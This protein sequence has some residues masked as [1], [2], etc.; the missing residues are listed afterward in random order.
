M[1]I[2]NALLKLASGEWPR[3][4]TKRLAGI[5]DD[6]GA[7]V[8]EA[9]FSR[10][11]RIIWERAIGARPRAPDSPRRILSASATQTSRSA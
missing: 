7:Q 1:R 8:Y 5:D 4:L 3:Q 2:R 6:L 10:G 11:G 9:K